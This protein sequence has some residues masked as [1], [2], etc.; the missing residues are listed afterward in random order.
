MLSEVKDAEGNAI[1]LTVTNETNQTI[2]LYWINGTQQ[3]R[4]AE[5]PPGGR[6]RQATYAGHR[7]RVTIPGRTSQ[8][9]TLPNA[10][11]IWNVR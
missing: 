1:E 4:Y 11:A 8:D 7:W 5:I 3:V 2:S 6:H 10:N 9:R